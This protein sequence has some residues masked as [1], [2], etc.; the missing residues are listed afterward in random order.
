MKQFYLDQSL[1]SDDSGF[2]SGQCSTPSHMT[3]V[4]CDSLLTS[5][6]KKQRLNSSP[7][8]EDMDETFESCQSS[9][10][11]RHTPPPA[12]KQLITMKIQSMFNFSYSN[13]S[14]TDMDVS[15]R[16]SCDVTSVV[17]METSDVTNSS[18]AVFSCL[19]D[20]RYSE[21]LV[22]TTWSISSSSRGRRTSIERSYSV[23]SDEANFMHYPMNKPP[24]ANI[25]KANK[26]SIVNK[27]KKIGRQI[28]ARNHDLTTLAVL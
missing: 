3:D 8:E 27:L 7:Y 10:V 12:V 24:V 9:L 19:N 18:G 4:S 21:S 17:A 28:Y 22:S 20:P 2:E 11:V 26:K 5:T 16:D 13:T 23:K 14:M 25:G 1:A 15:I 6:P